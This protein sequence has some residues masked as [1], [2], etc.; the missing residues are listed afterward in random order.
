MLDAHTLR[1][2]A[3]E[4]VPPNLTSIFRDVGPVSREMHSG[5]RWCGAQP[6]QQ[7]LGRCVGV[8]GS[9]R[10]VSAGWYEANGNSWWPSL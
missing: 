8:T 4:C 1:L 7:P 2:E 10:R 3:V 9:H 5:A 6:C